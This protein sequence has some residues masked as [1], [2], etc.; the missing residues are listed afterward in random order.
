MI[1][2]KKFIFGVIVMFS[3]VSI[4]AQKGKMQQK[5]AA[6][7]KSW[8]RTPQREEKLQRP[9]IELPTPYLPDSNANVDPCQG[10]W[11]E[12]FYAGRKDT[13]GDP[14]VMSHD[15]SAIGN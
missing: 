7:D 9:R 13:A 14:A 11:Y 10:V 2:N 1:I 3:S 15:P 6:M 4:K 8:F 12:G 5:G